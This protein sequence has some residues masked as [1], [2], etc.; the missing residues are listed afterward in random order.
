MNRALFPFMLAATLALGCGAVAID[1]P[2]DLG[3]GGTDAAI[4]GDAWDF[5]ASRADGPIGDG[6]SDGAPD[7]F[8]DADASR[9]GSRDADADAARDAQGIRDVLPDAAL[10]DAIV[11]P[12][13][14]PVLVDAGCTDS[15]TQPSRITC[16][17]NAQTGCPSGQ[18]CYPFVVPPSGPCGRETYGTACRPSG[19]G[20]QG[21]PCS[22]EGCAAGYICI[23]GS[24]GE[25]CARLCD[26]TLSGQCAR[27]LTCQPV[28]V[29]GFGVCA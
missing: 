18:G 10:P 27:G 13:A 28:D 19:S 11:L 29:S 25:S 17:A 7:G 26:L 9:D 4:P 15:G 14:P 1:P 21:E 6:A 20:T 5:D 8:F 23:V 22:R 12:D 24:G 2:L 3:D 16:D